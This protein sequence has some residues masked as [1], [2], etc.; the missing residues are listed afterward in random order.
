ML[1][2]GA[3]REPDMKQLE[4]MVGECPNDLNFTHFLT[5]FGEKMAGEAD[6]PAHATCILSTVQPLPTLCCYISTFSA[7]NN[8]TFCTMFHPLQFDTLTIHA[9]FYSTSVYS[10][11]FT[12]M[13]A[14]SL[15][16]AI[17]RRRRLRRWCASRQGPSTSPC[18]SPSSVTN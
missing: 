4:A 14:R 13:C 1:S 10:F 3:G 16:V 2:C 8:K 12:R 17:R 5:L 9:F 15:Q 7:F 11:V 18:S 6:A